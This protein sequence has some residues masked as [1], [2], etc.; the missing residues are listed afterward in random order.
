MIS[1]IILWAFTAVAARAAD[2]NRIDLHRDLEEMI[3][4][5]MQAAECTGILREVLAPELTI[6][7]GLELLNA[8]PDRASCLSETL[9][10]WP[11]AILVPPPPP[12]K[13]WY[14]FKVPYDTSHLEELRSRHNCVLDK[15]LASEDDY[16][17][18]LYAKC[19]GKF[20][21]LAEG[22]A[23]AEEEQREAAKIYQLEKK[24][25][26]RA[27]LGHRLFLLLFPEKR[28]EHLRLWNTSKKTA[29]E[30]ER[31]LSLYFER[32]KWGTFFGLDDSDALGRGAVAQLVEDVRCVNVERSDT[33]GFRDYAEKNESACAGKWL[34]GTESEERLGAL[35]KEMVAL[36]I[37]AKA[38]DFVATELHKDQKRKSQAMSE[39]AERAENYRIRRML[40]QFEAEKNRVGKIPEINAF[41]DKYES[42][43]TDDQNFQKL[44]IGQSMFKTVAEWRMSSQYGV[45]EAELS[46]LRKYTNAYFGAVNSDLYG[47]KGTVGDTAVIKEYLDRVLK[48]LP[49]YQATHLRR[50]SRLP[51]AFLEEH[52]VGKVVTYLAYTSTSKR[53]DWQWLKKQDPKIVHHFVI[54]PGRKGRPIYEL[55]TYS[56]EEEVLFEAGTKFKVLAREPNP[57]VPGSFNFVLAEADDDGNVV[58]ELPAAVK[59]APASSLKLNQF[60]K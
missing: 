6:Q 13:P 5:R 51:A 38:L 46:V 21:T 43:Q 40:A 1:A 2:D 30:E 24:F 25:K 15:N 27:E 33:Y 59:K 20:Y 41:C 55:S 48:K 57:G 19:G 37:Y 60:R 44:R 54:Y 53:P 45:T 10:S 52:Q 39:Q 4:L 3:I 32:E 11:R 29:T 23:F 9:D 35:R 16:V 7:S 18:E 31:S 34:S 58:A 50:D 42:I 47:G 22:K 12:P 14:E 28:E 8:S 17:K 56:T 36:P 49:P 26:A